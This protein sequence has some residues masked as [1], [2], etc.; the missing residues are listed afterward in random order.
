MVLGIWLLP[1]SQNSCFLFVKQVDQFLMVCFAAE[2][3][4]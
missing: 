4:W 2:D 3:I 1:A